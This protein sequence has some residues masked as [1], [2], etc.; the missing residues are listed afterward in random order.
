MKKVYKMAD[1]EA[2]VTNLVAEYISQGYRIKLGSQL[3]LTN[4]ETMIR[5]R[6]FNSHECYDKDYVPT[7]IVEKMEYYK[8]DH[9]EWRFK[10]CNVVRKYYQYVK[11]LTGADAY[12]EDRDA[13]INDILTRRERVKKQFEGYQPYKEID[14]DTNKRQIIVKN[15]LKNHPGFKRVKPDQIVSLVRYPDRYEIGIVGRKFLAVP[16]ATR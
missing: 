5:F 8:G 16:M 9:G 7:F 13:M 14:I 4:D 1:I 2:E 3:E 15:I 10:D 11:L 6:T 12:T